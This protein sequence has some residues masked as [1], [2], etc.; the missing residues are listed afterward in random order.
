MTQLI[1][2]ALFAALAVPLSLRHKRRKAAAK[3]EAENWLDARI[4]SAGE[5]VDVLADLAGGPMVSVGS[6]A[7]L[8]AVKDC[9]RGARWLPKAKFLK[10]GDKTAPD[11]RLD[12]GG[13]VAENGMFWFRSPGTGREQAFVLAEKDWE[14]LADLAAAVK[15]DGTGETGAAGAGD[16]SGTGAAGPGDSGEAAPG[17]GGDGAEG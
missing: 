16:S 10:E 3:A 17:P 2:A 13:N 7:T 1:G 9:L 14:R 11:T 4:A 5:G 8:A 6:P 15:A 12:L